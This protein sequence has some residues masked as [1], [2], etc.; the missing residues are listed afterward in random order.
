MSSIW[1]GCSAAATRDEE[2]RAGSALCSF[3]GQ[4]WDIYTSPL[5]VSLS[6][7][8]LFHRYRDQSQ[9]QP[10]PTQPHTKHKY[11]SSKSS[12]TNIKMGEECTCSTCGCKSDCKSCTCCTVCCSLLLPLLLFGLRLTYCIALNIHTSLHLVSFPDSSTKMM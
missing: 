3:G 2:S 12:E 1:E 8:S 10:I 11:R 7:L 4:I 9:H 5:P 6:P